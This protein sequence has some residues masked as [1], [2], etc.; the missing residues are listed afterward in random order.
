MNPRLV[1][2]WALGLVL[3]ITCAVAAAAG[4]VPGGSGGLLVVVATA[5]AVAGPALAITLADVPVS[6]PSMLFTGALVLFHLGLVVPWAAGW[7]DAPLWLATAPAAALDQAL[8]CIVL[9]TA[10]LQLGLLVGWRRFDRPLRQSRFD[11]SCKVQ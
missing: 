2:G 1:H 10:S 4:V 3:V 6:A 11:S 5:I 7:H 9:A 8:W